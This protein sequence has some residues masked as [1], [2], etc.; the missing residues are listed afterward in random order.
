LTPLA[1]QT[2]IPASSAQDA[3]KLLHLH[4]F[5]TTVV[6]K[7]YSTTWSK[8]EVCELMPTLGA[9]WRKETRQFFCLPLNLVYVSVV[10]GFSE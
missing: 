6:H 1:W 10:H 5:K 7:F 2:G 3:T 9:C 8:A 4:P